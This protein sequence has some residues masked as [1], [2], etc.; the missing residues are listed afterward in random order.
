MRRRRAG[1]VH[2]LEARAFAAFEEAPP[3]EFPLDLTLRAVALLLPVWL[4]LVLAV[5]AVA[6]GGITPNGSQAGRLR[7]WWRLAA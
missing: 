6:P 3:R 5:L 2:R 1:G 4:A 7:F